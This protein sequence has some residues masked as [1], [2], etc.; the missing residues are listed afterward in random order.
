LESLSPWKKEL[1]GTNIMKSSSI[2]KISFY[3]YSNAYELEYS[4]THVIIMIYELAYSSGV[5]ILTCLPLCLNIHM[6]SM[7]RSRVR[8][9]WRFVVPL[10]LPISLTYRSIGSMT[11]GGIGSFLVHAHGAQVHG[12]LRI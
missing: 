12:N 10:G 7:S 9:G 6:T 2:L 5:M 3:S 11:R 1:L 4:C 8:L